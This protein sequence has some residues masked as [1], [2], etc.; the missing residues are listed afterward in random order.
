M[1]WSVFSQKVGVAVGP[2]ALIYIPLLKLVAPKRS[3]HEVPFNLQ[4][5]VMSL[6]T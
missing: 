5:R 1:G 6:K 4:G 2:F 3:L